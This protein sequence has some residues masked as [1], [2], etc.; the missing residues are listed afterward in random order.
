[1]D[2]FN[3]YIGEYATSGDL[4]TA[5]EVGALKTPFLALVANNM[6]YDDIVYV[7][8]Y[9]NDTLT[10]TL[11]RSNNTWSAYS[12][13]VGMGE[14]VT[15][16]SNGSNLPFTVSGTSYT[17]WVS[18][19]SYGNPVLTLAN[20][21]FTLTFMYN[22]GTYDLRV[23]MNGQ[24]FDLT[25]GQR[26]TAD[27]A[28]DS[29]LD[30]TEEVNWCVNGSSVTTT[31]YHIDDSDIASATGIDRTNIWLNSLTYELMGA[32][33]KYVYI[34]VSDHSGGGGGDEPEDPGYF[35]DL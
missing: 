19:A 8:L 25:R 27:T 30:C 35:T 32:D 14:T 34:D 11:V 26:L 20:G 15:F 28:F 6:N 5:L 18:D 29:S 12:I 23:T 9:V 31:G 21:V 16:R 24:N 4:K 3:K 13:Q 7:D 17:S 10:A 33:D 1:M 22:Y 2:N